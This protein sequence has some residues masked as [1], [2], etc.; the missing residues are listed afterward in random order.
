MRGHR[1]PKVTATAQVS[2]LHLEHIVETIQRA[3]ETKLLASSSQRTFFT[4]VRL[5]LRHTLW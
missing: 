1:N 4:Q 5:H 3:I 2:F